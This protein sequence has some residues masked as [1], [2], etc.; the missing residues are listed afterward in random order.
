MR[1][2]IFINTDLAHRD[3]TLVKKPN[4]VKQSASYQSLSPLLPPSLAAS[5][6]MI[7][8]DHSDHLKSLQSMPPNQSDNYLSARLGQNTSN[9]KSIESQN[10]KLPPR[11]QKSMNFQQQKQ[12]SN[13][14][15]PLGENESQFIDISHL[16]PD[17]RHQHHQAGPNHPLYSATKHGQNAIMPD[18]LSAQ[19]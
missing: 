1:D 12:S 17:S 2:G 7:T 13:E 16:S 19:Q 11:Y 8:N 5:T 14:H 9:M 18:M 15:N 4:P 6:A 10:R 3:Y